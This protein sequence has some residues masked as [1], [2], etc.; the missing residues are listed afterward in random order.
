ML[1]RPLLIGMWVL[2]C[3]GTQQVPTVACLCAVHWQSSIAIGQH[4]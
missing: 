2:P 4:V 3:I 1:H